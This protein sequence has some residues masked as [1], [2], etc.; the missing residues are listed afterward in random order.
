MGK[1][2]G[3][4]AGL[5]VLTLGSGVVAQE[6]SPEPPPWFGGRVEM[7]EH[8]FAVTLP[9]DWVGI[10]LSVDAASQLEVA[11]G[12]IDPDLWPA[13]NAMLPG[14]LAAMGSNGMHLL[15]V[16]ATSADHC[17]WIAVPVS[18]MPADVAADG[19][20]KMHIDDPVSRDVEPPQA[21]ELPAGPAYLLRQSMWVEPV[22]MWSRLTSYVLDMGDGVFFAVCTTYDTRPDD[23]WL[24]IA[25]TIEFLPAE[26]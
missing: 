11:S 3:L 23:D 8:G 7:P 21:I 9:D 24:S 26:E 16:H 22:G 14:G 25:E 15:S 17:L 4:L 1:R 20:Y 18:A 2:V 10:D 19:L 6:P 13:D 12:F 5:L